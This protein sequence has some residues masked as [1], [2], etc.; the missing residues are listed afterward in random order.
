MAMEVFGENF[1]V[2]N[3]V[4]VKPVGGDVQ[5]LVLL[6]IYNWKTGNPKC[7]SVFSLVL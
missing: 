6:Y 4:H 7:V 2:T 5:I 1:V 3:E